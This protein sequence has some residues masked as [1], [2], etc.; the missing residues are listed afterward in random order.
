MKV[1]VLKNSEGRI[2][3]ARVGEEVV[4]VLDAQEVTGPGGTNLVLVVSGAEVSYEDL[5]FPALFGTPASA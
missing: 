1:V 4:P 2:V 5:P 3:F